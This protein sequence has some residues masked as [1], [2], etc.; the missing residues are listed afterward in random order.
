MKITYRQAACDDLTRQFRYYLVH[1]DVPEVA[2]RFKEAVRKTAK[3]RQRTARRRT[4][5]P[6]AQ[7]PAAK[8]TFLAMRFYF[9]V[10]EDA[11]RV[12]QCDSNSSR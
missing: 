11:I 6:I 10:E 2:M 8:S 3:G 4:A 5:V 12:I 9:V 7:S 1:L